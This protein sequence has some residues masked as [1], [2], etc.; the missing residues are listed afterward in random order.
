MTDRYQAVSNFATSAVQVTAALKQHDLDGIENANGKLYK[1][2]FAACCL[3]LA[4]DQL[5][6]ISGG[7]S[8]DSSRQ[9]CI[10]MSKIKES[11][12]RFYDIEFAKVMN[13]QELDI[14]FKNGKNYT[15][16]FLKSFCFAAF[17]C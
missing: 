1:T 16:P 5:S 11:V 4:A 10:K 15:L 7:A 3:L 14:N 13:D 17:K 2:L 8:F 12:L 6:I 9:L